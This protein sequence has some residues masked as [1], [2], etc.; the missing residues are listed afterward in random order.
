TGSDGSDASNGR[1]GTKAVAAPV[2]DAGTVDA[3]SRAAD[4]AT[5]AA[6]A[7]AVLEAVLGI[8]VL[9]M[10]TRRPMGGVAITVDAIP[11]GETD[12]AGRLVLG[13]ERGT[14]HQVEAQS[15]GYTLQ[16]QAIASLT[17]VIELVFRL[18]PRT[19]GERYET[20]VR[21]GRV[22]LP[23]VSIPAEEA[24]QTAGTSGDPVRVLASLPGVSQVVW[25]AAVFVVRGSNPG[26][27]GFFVDG[28]RVP[29]MFHL[30]LGPSIIH[31][32]LI[33]G[34]DFYPGAFPEQ[35]GRYVA[36]VVSIRTTPPPADRVHVAADVTLYD[37]GAIATVPINGGRGVATAAARYSYTGALLSLIEPSTSL[38]YGDYQLRIDH[39]LLGGR[40]TLFAFGS[41]DR[42]SW[43]S[44]GI[45]STNE[46][47]PTQTAALQF[48]RVD[49]RWMGALAGGRL[50][51]G[52]TG[53]VDRGQSTLYRSPIAVG[54]VT[55][56]PRISWTRPF[57]RSW[58]LVLGADAELQHFDAQP[59]PFQ[60]KQSDLARSRNALSQGTFGALRYHPGDRL[61]V[62]PGFR[63][64]IF[65]E[66]G[67]TR[68][69]LEPRLDARFA[70]SPV[71][72]L[73]A[74]AGRFAQMP[75]L[76]VNVAGFEAFGLR[77]IGLQTSTAVSGGF[78]ARV[79]GD[80]QVE[81][82]AFHQR[83][84]VTDLRNLD[85]NQMMPTRDDY[86]ELRE[87]TGTGAEVLIRR[88]SHHR[89]YGWL[90]YTLSYSQRNVDGVIVRSDW[91]QRHLLNLV[92]GWR[93]SGATT[94]SAR[95]H[96]NPGRNA[97]LY[98]MGGGYR[99]IPP[100]YQIDVRAQHR[101]LFDRFILD[102]FVDI[103]NATF[104]RETVQYSTRY[105]NNAVE[106]NYL[107]LVLPTVGVH[108]EF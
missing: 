14:S 107:R 41:L 12:D 56:A 89:F 95:V 36:G 96:L 77:S 81:V 30:A 61:T 23:S 1:G 88:P 87:G 55:G 102:A 6:P 82:T 27:T 59:E 47:I 10:G 2:A 66:E 67:T 19:T 43:A 73:K 86:L 31:P 48:H 13:V 9:E 71:I 34:L 46:P 94:L 60:G 101:F 17:D 22:E 90:A 84:R 93:P 105:D 85:I 37:A 58:D 35:F 69:A 79:F 25:P 80:T 42:L 52:I 104:N 5:A 50:L 63:V 91:D 7:E 54:S 98:Q 15:P 92:G 16:R 100:Y 49:V 33:G 72:A 83:M 24:R 4:A 44:P 70:L 20:R 76:P 106:P 8:Q 108:G 75:S 68:T 97:P 26:N 62:A 40:A 53:G 65:A 45:L 57:D 21:A 64:D 99:E 39:P 18:A 74:N 11:R 51:A 29:A 78:D 32:N 3:S 38:Q 28:V 103:A